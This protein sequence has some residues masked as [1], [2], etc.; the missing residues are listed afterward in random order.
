MKS[1]TTVMKRQS[2]G[3]TTDMPEIVEKLFTDINTSIMKFSVEVTRSLIS[4]K[5]SYLIMNYHSKIAEPEFTIVD[6]QS[7][8]N[9]SF[10]R[11]FIKRKHGRKQSGFR[12]YS[13]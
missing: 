7:K 9:L 12:R 2:V 13:R 10:V 1:K 8:D 3:C 4:L 5:S 6:N 11:N